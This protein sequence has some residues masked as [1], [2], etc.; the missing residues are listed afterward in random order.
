[1]CVFVCLHVGRL[2][3]AQRGGLCCHLISYSAG[4]HPQVSGGKVLIAVQ[5]VNWTP[6]GVLCEVN[7]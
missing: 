4:Q 6:K 2:E 7:S 3:S 1:M 5:T